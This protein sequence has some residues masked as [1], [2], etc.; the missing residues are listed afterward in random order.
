M[1]LKLASPK[2][3]QNEMFVGREGSR[4]TREVP[5][6]SAGLEDS[7][8]RREK[9]VIGI[10]MSTQLLL[11]P[12]PACTQLLATV[13]RYFDRKRAMRTDFKEVHGQVVKD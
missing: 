9:P 1:L 5:M 11:R 6:S 4:S 7:R 2:S 12:W 8:E 13:A 10:T 3:G